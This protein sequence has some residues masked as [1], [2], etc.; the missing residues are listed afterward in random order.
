MAD[1]RKSGAAD[2]AE[3]DSKVGT[4][5]PLHQSIRARIAEDMAAFEDA[6]GEVEVLGNTPLRRVTKTARSTAFRGVAKTG[7]VPAA[8]DPAGDDPGKA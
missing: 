8:R 6:G 3:K 7:G 4:Y 1:R 5:V 2:T